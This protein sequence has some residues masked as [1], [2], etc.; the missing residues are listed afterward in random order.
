MVILREESGGEQV[1]PGDGGSREL[2]D[3]PMVIGKG[4]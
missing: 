3:F 2:R 4:S 1:T